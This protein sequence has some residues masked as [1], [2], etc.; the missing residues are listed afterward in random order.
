MSGGQ[1]ESKQSWDL[2]A[3]HRN[4]IGSHRAP[5]SAATQGADS[6]Y[7]VLYATARHPPTRRPP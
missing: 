6:T 4:G 7:I 2:W 3:A 1:L 5:A